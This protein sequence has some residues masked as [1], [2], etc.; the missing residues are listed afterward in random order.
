MINNSLILKATSHGKCPKS[1]KGLKPPLIMALIKERTL[2]SPLKMAQI[3]ERTL[4]LL[5]MAKINETA[6]APYEN[7]PNHRKD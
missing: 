7:G 4:V 6:I 5:R 2:D 1:L 3:T